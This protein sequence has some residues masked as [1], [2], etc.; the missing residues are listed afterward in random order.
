MIIKMGQ[1]IAVILGQHTAIKMLSPN[2]SELR[3]EQASFYA[4]IQVPLCVIRRSKTSD[5]ALTFFW[6]T[7]VVCSDVVRLQ[8]SGCLATLVVG[9]SDVV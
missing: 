9:G 3:L 6:E 4:A 5:Q 7:E 2:S 1:Q 8:I